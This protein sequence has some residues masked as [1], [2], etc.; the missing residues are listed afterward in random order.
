MKRIVYICIVAFLMLTGS[1]KT[2]NVYGLNPD[3]KLTTSASPDR[4]ISHRFQSGYWT[5]L[6]CNGVEDGYLEGVL[7]VHCVMF[8]HPGAWQ[9]M[10]MR[11]TG[12]ITNPETGEQFRIMEIDKSDD[13]NVSWHANIIGN[14]GS[15]YIII[16]SMTYEPF[17]FTI[18]KTVCP[19]SQGD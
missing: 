7:D 9:W 1:S 17:S 12:K 10:T 4:S 15:H 11:F 13:N 3:E 19:G 16:G 5:P 18:E 8:G 14:Q 6:I 2:A